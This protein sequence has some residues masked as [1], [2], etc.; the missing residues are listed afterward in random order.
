[1]MKIVFAEEK[2]VDLSSIAIKFFNHT[3]DFTWKV[4]EFS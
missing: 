3:N 1:M 2:D 4:V